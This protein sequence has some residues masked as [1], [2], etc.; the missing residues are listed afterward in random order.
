MLRRSLDLPGYWRAWGLGRQGRRAQS[1]R[2]ESEG[3][4]EEGGKMGRREGG[5][6]KNWKDGRAKVE[7]TREI[8]K[9]RARSGG[10]E[11]GVRS[12]Q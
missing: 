7:R 3:A 10:Y 5:K 6:D 4:S 9:R 11:W 1:V 8:G 12:R 2:A